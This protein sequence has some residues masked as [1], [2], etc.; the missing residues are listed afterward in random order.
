VM[1]VIIKPDKQYILIYQSV[2]KSIDHYK[3]FLEAQGF[4]VHCSADKKSII[5]MLREREAAAVIIFYESEQRPLIDFL[6]YIMRQHP[7][8]Q[9]IY[10][11]DHL[12]KDLIQKMINKAHINYLLILPFD[13]SEIR[14]VVEKAIKRYWFLTQPSRRLNELADITAE[15]LEDVDKYR[16]EAGTDALTNLLNRRSFDKILEKALSLFY[17]KN[18]AFSLI[19]IDLDDF[20]KLNDTYGHLAGDEVLRIFGQILLK[21]MRHE[22]HA[23]RYGGEEFAILANGDVAQNIKQ[24]VNRIRVEI[25]N[26]N[27]VFEGRI[28]H[29]TFSAGLATMQ[30]SFTK[31]KLIAAADQALYK[32]KKEGKD[33]VIDFSE[34]HDSALK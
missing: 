26:K 18:L 10:V 32:A 21:N 17:D 27:I 4:D 11:T 13:M 24:F 29:T 19:L 1:A 6:R 16:N 9:R 33:C 22:D 23:F 15:L 14:E 34:L 12:D 2:D 8:I 7:H 5:E 20:K 3:D 31:E 25:K 30:Q 28:I